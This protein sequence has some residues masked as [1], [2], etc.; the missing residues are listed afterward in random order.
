[1][2]SGKQA[3][4]ITKEVK[5]FVEKKEQPKDKLP[6]VIDKYQEVANVKYI[7]DEQVRNDQMEDWRISIYN[8]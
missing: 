6:E 2:I 7:K 3:D 8:N 4:D 1:M 5:E